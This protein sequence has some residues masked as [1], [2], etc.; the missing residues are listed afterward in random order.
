MHVDK[1]STSNGILKRECAVTPSGSNVAA[2]PDDATT[3]TIFPLLLIFDIIQL[4][5]KVLPVPP[6]PWRKKNLPWFLETDSI[7]AAY[8]V[9]WLLL[10][11]ELSWCDLAASAAQS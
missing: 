3:N 7:I 1:L 11:E 9:N 6:W 4:Y 10:R 8:A 5:I 2:I